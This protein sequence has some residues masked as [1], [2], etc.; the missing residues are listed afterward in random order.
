MSN[1]FIVEDPTELADVASG[2]IQ[3]PSPERNNPSRNHHRPRGEAQPPSLP[4]IKRAIDLLAD[5]SILAP[6]EVVV[7]FLHRGSK[8]LVAAPSKAGKTWLLI[9]LAISVAQG[10]PWLDFTTVQGKVLL[11]NFEIQEFQIR[12]RIRSVADAK[13][14]AMNDSRMHNLNNLDVWTLRGHARPFTDL[15]PVISSQISNSNYSLIII[16]PIY[17][18]MAGMNESDAGDISM[19]V[20]EFER[21]AVESGASVVYV[22]HYAKGNQAT[23]NV[24]DRMSGSGVF[25]RDADSMVFLSELKLAH[26]YRFETILRNHPPRPAVA[27]RFD[28][29]LIHVVP[30]VVPDKLAGSGG[31]PR[32]ADANANKLLQILENGPLR[33]KEWQEQSGMSDGVFNAARKHLAEEGLAEKHNGKWR[34]KLEVIENPQADEED[35]TDDADEGDETPG[36]YP[37]TPPT[38]PV[39]VLLQA[40]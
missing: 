40:G 19:L 5:E 27:V 31:R 32:T 28:Y 1:P 22:H 35:E 39:K 17:K 18:G 4:P 38:Q 36:H 10:I 34:V 20:N 23:K 15:L 24:I 30:N 6:A 21:L 12:E 16:D 11:V 25:A 26:H 37:P 2:I 29:P 8:A 9:D 7:G 13:M 33:F 14:A 3:M